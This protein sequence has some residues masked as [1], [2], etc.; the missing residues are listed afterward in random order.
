MNLAQCSVFNSSSYIRCK[1]PR[2]TARQNR[3]A[4]TASSPTLVSDILLERERELEDRLH[5]VKN[6]LR[7]IAFTRATTKSQSTRRAC[8]LRAA[9][10]SRRRRAI[11]SRL[12]HVRKIREDALRVKRLR[13]EARTELERF[14]AVGID[15]ELDEA[16][17]REGW[18]DAVGKFEELKRDVVQ[19]SENLARDWTGIEGTELEEELDQEMN[20]A[21]ANNRNP[22]GRKESDTLESDTLENDTEHELFERMQNPYDSTL[23]D[24]DDAQ[25]EENV[26][27]R[28]E[29]QRVRDLLPVRR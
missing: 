28:S 17:L 16:A 27:Y 29:V 10:H 26:Q 5:R 25:S 18:N 20:D 4:H 1:N 12:C 8:L 23:A 3:S 2:R 13:N 21:M 22:S 9:I 7:L 24:E 14:T 6:D 15:E 11:E 19:V